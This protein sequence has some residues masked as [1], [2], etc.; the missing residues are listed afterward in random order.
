MLNL[1]SL[2][3]L[4]ALSQMINERWLVDVYFKLPLLRQLS[5]KIKLYSTAD[6]PFKLQRDS[7]HLSAD[8]RVV[9][10]QLIYYNT[11]MHTI[12]LSYLYVDN[13]KMSLIRTY[14]YSDDVQASFYFRN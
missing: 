5:V 7:L 1:H 8:T 12:T 11:F 3:L 9:T 10:I 14:S 6:P 2:Q 4:K 13:K